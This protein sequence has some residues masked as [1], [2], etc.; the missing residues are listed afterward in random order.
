M[1]ARKWHNQNRRS[2]AARRGTESARGDTPFMAPLLS[3]TPKRQP[4]SKAELR[5]QAEAALAVYAG[6]ITKCP[7]DARTR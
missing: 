4:P 7:T 2:L 6:F 3:R 5:A 1:S